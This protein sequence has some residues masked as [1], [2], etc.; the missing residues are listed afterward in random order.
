MRVVLIVI[1][2]AVVAYLLAKGIAAWRA[3]RRRS[4]SRDEER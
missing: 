4:N 1:G 3:E 2:A